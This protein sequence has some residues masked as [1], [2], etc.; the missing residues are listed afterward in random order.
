MYD[1]WGSIHWRVEV[2]TRHWI[3]YTCRYMSAHK[4]IGTVNCRQF[5]NVSIENLD[6][7]GCWIW[8]KTVKVF[9][10]TCLACIWLHMILELNAHGNTNHFSRWRSS[11]SK[12]FTLSPIYVYTTCR[13]CRVSPSQIFPTPKLSWKC[14]NRWT[15]KKVSQH[16][17]SYPSKAS[18]I[19]PRRHRFRHHF[20]C[21]FS[22]GPLLVLMAQKSGERENQLIW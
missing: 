16:A 11:T 14:T 12:L 13:L 18:N 4:Y 21:F 9:V 6:L 20:G 2:A 5:P 7:G 8:R 15:P 19:H 1:S 17:E 22:L 10:K 3:I